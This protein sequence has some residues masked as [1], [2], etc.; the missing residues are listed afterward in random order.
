MNCNRLSEQLLRVCLYISMLTM[1]L[2]LS[3]QPNSNE[4]W[5][6]AFLLCSLILMLFGMSYVGML[7]SKPVSIFSKPVSVFLFVVSWHIYFRW[8]DVWHDAVNYHAYTK[9][10]WILMLLL[11]SAADCCYVVLI[12]H[13]GCVLACYS[14]CCHYSSEY[15][16]SYH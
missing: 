14:R 15:R 4:Y 1:A 7:K 3:C 5:V 6:A 13:K 12:Y 9:I 2:F 11:L 16:S 8:T 10:D